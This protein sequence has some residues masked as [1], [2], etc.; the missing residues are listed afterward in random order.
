MGVLELAAG[1]VGSTFSGWLVSDLIGVS[2]ANITHHDVLLLRDA[3]K[4]KHVASS[5]V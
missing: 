1:Q 2:T 5:V 3:C 4:R